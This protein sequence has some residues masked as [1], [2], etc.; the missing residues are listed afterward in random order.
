MSRPIAWSVD[1]CEGV[2]FARALWAIGISRASQLGEDAPR[3]FECCA[4]GQVDQV[5]AGV[6]GVGGAG[7]RFYRQGGAAE[8]RW[9]A[10]GRVQLEPGV[11]GVGPEG[12]GAAYSG[13]VDL[14]VGGVGDGYGVG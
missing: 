14:G 6:E 13:E 1:N 10:V 5:Y 9:E 7:H 2:E 3:S 4:G 12:Y 11:G 8:G